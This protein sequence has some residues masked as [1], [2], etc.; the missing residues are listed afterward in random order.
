LIAHIADKGYRDLVV[1]LF[2]YLF[3]V[4]SKKIEVKYR[5]SVTSSIIKDVYSE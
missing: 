2:V 4:K 1:Y 5:A 3:F